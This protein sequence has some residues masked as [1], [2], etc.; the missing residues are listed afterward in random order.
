MAPSPP[1]ERSSNNVTSVL[2][3]AVEIRNRTYSIDS[4]NDNSPILPVTDKRESTNVQNEK[5]RPVEE[6]RNVPSPQKSPKRTP[7]RRQW[8]ETKL[9]QSELTTDT[10]KLIIKQN[11]RSVSKMEKWWKKELDSSGNSG[12]GFRYGRKTWGQSK[13]V[14]SIK[15]KRKRKPKKFKKS[16]IVILFNIL[17][18]S[19]WY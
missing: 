4:N 12:Y 18:R 7:S 5:E 10:N 14:K 17:P 15:G 1:R 16:G 13:P 11:H 9:I 3:T 2:E 8:N 19:Y 6:A